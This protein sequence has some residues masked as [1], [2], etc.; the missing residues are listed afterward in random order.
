MWSAT[1]K[2]QQKPKKKKHEA[3]LKEATT[4]V[5]TGPNLPNRCYEALNNWWARR[6]K[7]SEIVHDRMSQHQT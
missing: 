6:V 2:V 5:P 3:K 7:Y 4:N 1:K